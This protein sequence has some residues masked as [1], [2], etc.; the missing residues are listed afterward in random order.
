MNKVRIPAVLLAAVILVGACPAA[1]AEPS[2]QPKK[3]IKWVDFR[4]PY[5]ALDMAY[6]L[7]VESHG[8]DIQLNWVELLAYVTA[9]NGNNFKN[10]KP[11]A[12]TKVADRL[13]AGETMAELTIKSKYYSYYLE[14]YTAILG[15]FVGEYRAERPL[16]E[17]PEKTEW[18]E[19]YGLK[20]FS[21][22][23]RGFAYSH[24]DDFGNGRSYGYKRKHLGHDLMALTG[25]PVIA[26][27][28][29][30][31]EA[32]GWN[33]YGG[34]RVGIRS[35]DGKRYYYYAHLRQNRPFHENLKQGEPVAAGQVIG[36]VGRTGYSTKENVSNLKTSHLHFGL[37]L[38]FD[39]SQKEGPTEIWIDLY[40]LTRFLDKNKATVYRVAETKEYHKKY[41]FEIITGE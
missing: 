14:A 26:V 24:C 41:G 31:V 40:A 21:P 35:L 2:E 13:R 7:D 29:G 28:G 8:Q 25:T 17:D 36:Y 12:L 27:E 39:E 4:V 34:W 1:N 3:F 30:I 38:I 16:K 6:K 5:E 18:V 22:V 37:Q 9:Q 11:S 19:K 23:A 32:M 20:V 33:K 10:F 15:N